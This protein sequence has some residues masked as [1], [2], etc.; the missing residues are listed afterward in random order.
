MSASENN[1]LEMLIGYIVLGCLAVGA[2][3]GIGFVTDLFKSHTTTNASTPDP[4]DAQI[5]QLNAR[6][7]Q[8]E[9]KPP[10]HHYE[11]R[12]DGLRTWRFDPATGETCIKLTTP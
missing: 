6:I 12:N 2:W 1:A 4:R 11:L 7:A 10:E 8:L 9:A 5:A 3:K